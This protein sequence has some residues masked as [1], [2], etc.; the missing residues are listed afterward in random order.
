M[1]GV[2]AIIIV[3]S[4]MNG[5]RE[6]FT[7]RLLGINGHLNIFS[8]TNEIS[9]ESIKSIEDLSNDSYQIF[10]LVETQALLISDENAKGVYVRSYE[11]EDINNINFLKDKI[12][13]GKIYSKNTNELIIGYALADKLDLRIN[14]KVIAQ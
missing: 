4:V 11:K 12:V 13:S 3:M 14:D 10:P 7:S 5:F 1:I 8:S 9:K 6:E 2:A